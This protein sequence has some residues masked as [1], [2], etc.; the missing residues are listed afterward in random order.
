MMS[1]RAVV[2]WGLGWATTSKVAPPCDLQLLLAAGRELLK[3]GSLSFSPYDGPTWLVSEREYPKSEYFRSKETDAVIS[4]LLHSIDQSPAQIQGEEKL[5]ALLDVKC[6]L[7]REGIG[8]SAF[9]I[10]H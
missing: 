1:N 3:N 4:F 5:N 10:D 8:G 9:K 7:W 2:I 6:G